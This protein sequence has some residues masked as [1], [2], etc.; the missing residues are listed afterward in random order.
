MGI[1]IT[2]RLGLVGA[3]LTLGLSSPANAQEPANWHSDT[4]KTKSKAKA[5][6]VTVVAGKQFARGSFYRWLFG[7]NYRD[8]WTTPIRVP[9]LDLH[10]YAGGLHPTKEGGGNQTKSLRLENDD[11]AEYVFR[12]SEKSVDALPEQL[13]GTPIAGIIRD[14]VSSQHPGGAVMTA[15]IVEAVGILHPTPHLAVMADDSVLGKFRHDFGGRLGM[16]EEYPNVPKDKTGFGGASK[17]IDSDELLKLLNSDAA[18]HV[19]A[20]AFLAARLVDFLIND[21]DRHEGNWKWARL[22]GKS[23]D[24]WEPIARDRDHAFV[25]F[26]GA[27]I[28]VGRLAVAGVVKFG[29]VPDV[30]ELAIPLGFNARILSGLEKPVWDSVARAVQADITDSV[31]DAATRALP[32]EWRSS[33]PRTVA[34]LKARRELI[35]KSADEFYHMLARRVDIHGSDSAD[36]A[37]ITREKDGFVD[38]RLASKGKTFFKRRFDAR[39]T[40]ELLVYLHGG[41]DTAAVV[42][43]ADKSIL[44]R[45]IGGNGTNTLID[46]SSV[47]GHGH[48]TRL[49]DQG[50]VSGVSYGSDSIYDRRPWEKLG[51]TLAPPP[52]DDGGSLAPL[53][54]LSDHRNIGITPKIG[55]TKYSYGFGKR[56]YAAMYGVAAEYATEFHAWRVTAEADHRLESS[57]LHFSAFG[58][59]SD[60]ESVRYHGLGNA[61]A[62]APVDRYYEVRQRQWLFRPTV[63]FAIGQSLD[64]S[65]GPVIQ[66]A[67]T[68]SLAN[69]FLSSTQP[70]GFGT[71]N[72]AGLRLGAHYEVHSLP[73]KDVVEHTHHRILIDA[74]AQY[75]PAMMD[76]RSAFE[77]AE[78]TAGMSTTLPV[79]THPL[80]V[81]RAGGKKVFGDA[82]FFEAA[83]IGGEGT[84]RYMDTERYAGDA[85]LYATTELRVPLARFTLL[86]PLRA[87]VLGL[88]EAG[89]VYVDG[90][91]PGGWH[92]RAGGGVWLG[93]GDASPVLTLTHT[94]EPGHGGVHLRLGLNF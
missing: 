88:A 28:A 74:G 75:F 6:S 4:L 50:V 9:V 47:G 56:P 93:R 62:D 73:E 72:E 37:W 90:A 21:N 60:F 86:M 48:P 89:R 59:M 2:R 31:I 39:E 33:T 10:T 91:S 55:I 69:R 35:P 64:L 16:I 43:A 66:H 17:I 8:V 19:D 68:D 84:M 25:S 38:V 41:N 29:R 14:Q 18:E 20:R 71:F 78:V 13:S 79:A 44:V 58:R 23:K 36:H 32:A 27:A 76:V 3:V 53:V 12:L 92:S 51:D 80:F 81:A 83:T 65:L 11:G 82:P 1:I 54:G 22:E 30:P 85:A 87:G 63:G 26:E 57:P 77:E 42:G 46:S 52:P 70:Y 67:S 34:L 45:V 7:D 40:E 5:E 49:Y 94:T 24:Q 61:T 15:P